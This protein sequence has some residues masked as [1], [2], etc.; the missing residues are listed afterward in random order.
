M[1]SHGSL[2]Y[3]SRQGRSVEARHSRE[4]GNPVRIHAKVTTNPLRM[5]LTSW[6]ITC[7]LAAH[8]VAPARGA[9][10]DDAL[11]SL[12]QLAADRIDSV[13]REVAASTRALGDEYRALAAERQAVTDADRAAWTGRGTTEG[14]TTGFRTWPEGAPTP[15]FQAPFPGYYNYRG[16]SVTEETVAHL[17]DFDRLLPLFRAA[18][19]SFDFSWVYLTTADDMM[20]IYPYVPLDEAV[21][22]AMPTRQVYYTAADFGRRAVG[23]T[24]PYLDLVGAGMMITASYPVYSGDRLLGVASRD[25]TL[26]QLSRSVLTHLAG[27]DSTSAFIVD[28]RGLAIDASDPRLASEITR[29]NGEKKSAVLFYRSSAA[30]AKKAV[31][32]AVVSRFDW[33]NEVTEQVLASAARSGAPAAIDMTIDGR[34]VLAARIQSTGWLVVLVDGKP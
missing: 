32:G 15:A 8:C 5:R 21:N 4:R 6:A 31:P 2:N 33:V 17:R 13:F 28:R 14:N 12:V 27:R 26:K 20:L 19:R 34:K 23:W 22:N 29:V 18:Y 24:E 25:I 9:G 3:T 1:R 30:L 7:I 11:K 10:S 16:S